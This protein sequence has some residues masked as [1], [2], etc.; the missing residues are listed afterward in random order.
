MLKTFADD[1]KSV[2]QEKN[3]T[4]KNI[5]QQTRLNITV[6]ENIENGDF[7]FQPPPYI[8]AFLKEYINCLGLDVEETLFDFDLAKSGKYKSKRQNIAAPQ[9]ENPSPQKNEIPEIDNE[10]IEKKSETPD[11][12]SSD[13][14][15]G[16]LPGKQSASDDTGQYEINPVKSPLPEEQITEK[17]LSLK[18]PEEKKNQYSGNTPKKNIIASIFNSPVVRNISLIIFAA[19]ILLGLYSLVNILFFDGSGD[20]PDVIRKNFDEVVKEQEKK[21]LGKRSPEE[22]QDSI[23]RAEEEAASAKDSITLKITALSN[24]TIFLVTDSVDYNSPAKISFEKNQKGE[25]KAKKVFFISSSNTGSFR[26]SI[27]EIPLKFDMQTASKV[28]ITKE[29]LVK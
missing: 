14:E 10:L 7:T 24:G 19:L 4:L 21:I 26:A 25:F 29:G 12:D 22:I 13:K 5:S 17:K 16:K 8:R 27:N 6:L 20:K 23:R 28:K 2:R 15:K 9:T 3:L 18:P 1:L 11:K